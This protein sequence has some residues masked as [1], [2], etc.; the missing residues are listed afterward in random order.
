MTVTDLREAL[1]KLEAEGHGARPVFY[2]DCYKD[3]WDETEVGDLVLEDMDYGHLAHP[4][5]IPAVKIV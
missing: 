5:K 1:Q 2:V 3:R 4:K